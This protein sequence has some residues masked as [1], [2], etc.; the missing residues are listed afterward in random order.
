MNHR[1]FTTPSR[2]DVPTDGDT[3]DPCSPTLA[4]TVGVIEKNLVGAHALLDQIEQALYGVGKDPNEKLKG[5]CGGGLMG[6]LGECQSS[7]LNITR[8]LNVILSSIESVK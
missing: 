1:S 2:C 6:T 4:N 5:S 3:C 8:R 7:S